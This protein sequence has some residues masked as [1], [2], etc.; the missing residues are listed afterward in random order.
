MKLKINLAYIGLAVSITALWGLRRIGMDP[1]VADAVVT[2]LMI[3]LGFTPAP[4]LAKG[5][6]Q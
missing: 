1:D 5:K 2:A 6:A 3:G 4:K